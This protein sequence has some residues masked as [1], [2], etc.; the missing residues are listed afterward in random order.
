MTDIC[1]LLT[2]NAIKTGDTLDLYGTYKIDGVATSLAGYTI[3]SQVRDSRG[4]L[5]D[6]FTVSLMDQGLLPGG[7][8]LS[9]GEIDWPAGTYKCD[10]EFVDGTDFVRSSE[11]FLI[12]VEQDITHV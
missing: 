11:T 10:I 6:A 2:I 3:T 9:A 8:K 5:I 12:P 7:F 1:D 4:T